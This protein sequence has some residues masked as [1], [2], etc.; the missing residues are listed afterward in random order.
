[1]RTALNTTAEVQR[2]RPRLAILPIG[3]TEQHGPHLPLN[4]DILIIEHLAGRLA[5]KLGGY[6]LPTLPFSVSHMHRGQCGTVWLRNDTLAR[7]IRDV[8]LSVR[9]EGFKEFLILN[10][11]GGNLHL[12]SVVQ[13][14]NL[15]LPDLLSLVIKPTDVIAESGIFPNPPAWRHADEFETAAILHL[16]PDLVRRNKLRDQ[17][18]ALERELLRYMPFRKISRQT[19]TGHPTRATAEQGRRAL[20]FIAD[21]AVAS[22]RASLKKVARARRTR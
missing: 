17:P 7:V 9:H 8:A 20:E 16:R 19:Y 10:G 15:D 11:H 3:A 2:R 14:L 6:C 4:T 5:A 13:D 21:R 12:V 22:F 18:A 1:M